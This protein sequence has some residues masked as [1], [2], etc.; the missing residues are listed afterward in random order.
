MK[1]RGQ[2]LG[3]SPMGLFMARPLPSSSKLH[4]GKTSVEEVHVEISHGL[5][6]IEDV[7]PLRIREGT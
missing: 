3:L 7:K 4:P 1:G 5:P 6:S 2:I